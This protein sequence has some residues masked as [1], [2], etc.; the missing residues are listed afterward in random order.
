MV[1]WFGKPGRPLAV[2]FPKDEDVTYL[3]NLD[4]ELGTHLLNDKFLKKF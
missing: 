3:S 1:N 2:S 4:R